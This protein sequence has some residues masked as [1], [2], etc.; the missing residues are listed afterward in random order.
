MLGYPWL[1]TSG[2][3]RWAHRF[4]M[5][6][7][8]TVQFI[9]ASRTNPCW[10]R[11]LAD[12]SRAWWVFPGAGGCARPTVARSSSCSEMIGLPLLLS[13][14]RTAWKASWSLMIHYVGGRCSGQ[15][16]RSHWTWWISWNLPPPLLLSTRPLWEM[17]I[18]PVS[19]CARLRHIFIFQPCGK[20]C[21]G[22]TIRKDLIIFYVCLSYLRRRGSFPLCCGLGGCRIWRS[23]GWVWRRGGAA[24]PW[25]F[26]WSYDVK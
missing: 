21:P 11:A 17:T 15:P 10:W 5:I 7:S 6:F 3:R 18:R 1:P 19:H 2:A 22:V 14:F 4:S 13:F 8:N 24:W 23:A 20:D 25:R 9:A 16:I 12:Y 26:W